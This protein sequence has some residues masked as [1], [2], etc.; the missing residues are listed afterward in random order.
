VLTVSK[1]FF[2]TKILKRRRRKKNPNPKEIFYKFL[3]LFRKQ[4][5]KTFCNSSGF[6]KSSEELQKENF[7]NSGGALLKNLN[8]HKFC[9]L[10]K[11]N[12]L[13]KYILLYSKKQVKN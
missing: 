8:T 11:W 10:E 1:T 2:R 3:K 7:K 5:R 9:V 4:K 13:V 12:A 6:S